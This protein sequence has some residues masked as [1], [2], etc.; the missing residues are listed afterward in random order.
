MP[1]V[2]EPLSMEEVKQVLG[3]KELQVYQLSR[4]IQKLDAMIEQLQA[5]Q[6]EPED[7]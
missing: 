4:H 7:S 5:N 1:T 2:I 6:P 3:D